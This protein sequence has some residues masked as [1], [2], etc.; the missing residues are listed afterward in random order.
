MSSPAIPLGFRLAVASAGFKKPGRN[1][2]ALAVSDRPAVAAGVFTRNIFKAAPVQLGSLILQDRETVRAVVFNAGN[3]NACTGA[4]GLANC[5]LSQEYLAAAT[6]LEPAE[7]LPASTGVIGRQFNMDLWQAAI[8][9]LTD[10]LGKA[11]V[12]DFARAIMTTDAFPKFGGEALSLPGGTVTLAGVAKGAGMICP[13][14]AT[15]L[16]LVLCD[17]ELCPAD[18]RAMF[19]RVVDKTF[20]RATVDGDTSTNDTLYGLANGA[21][22]VKI[23]GEDLHALESALTRILQDLA[24]K[25]VRD[26][27]GASKVMHIHVRGAATDAEAERIARTVG[28]SPLVKT[29]MYGKDANWG[30]II[31]AVGRAG[32]DFIPSDVKVSLCG[33]EVF[34]YEQPVDKDLD[35]LLEGPLEERD[36]PID[37]VVGSGPGKCLLL[38]SDLTHEYVTINADY[39]T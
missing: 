10:S 6:G 30:R 23:A 9:D 31:A 7:I 24:Y 38:A 1:D 2:L 36:I 11:G 4:E 39:R 37:I 20:N 22:G 18:W 14:M 19:S 8:P 34:R 15:M 33:I 16:S 12:E 25:L 32:V 26:G 35:A 28:H 13:N 29:A 21:S 5:R 27:E 3:A 17:A